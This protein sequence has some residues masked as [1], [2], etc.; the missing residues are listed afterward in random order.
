MTSLRSRLFQAIA[1]IVVLCVG[2]TLTLGLLLTR[3]AVDQATLEDVDHQAALIAERERVAIS[4]FTYLK[5]LRPYLRQQH[6]IY[7]TTAAG[8]PESA[9]QLLR[10]GEAAKGSVTLGHT[11]YFFA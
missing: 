3:R 10:H 1:L 2:L 9:Q 8:L 4:P 11:G 6:E 7:H 5:P